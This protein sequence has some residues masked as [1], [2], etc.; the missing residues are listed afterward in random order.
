MG[1]L[2]GGQ[3]FFALRLH[4][5]GD[6]SLVSVEVPMEVERGAQCRILHGLSALAY[7]YREVA[8]GDHDSAGAQDL[9]HCTDGF[10][11]HPMTSLP[12]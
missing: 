5:Q 10:P 9:S 7:L 1:A 6:V 3:F 12:G 2:L 4:E 8:E 11:V